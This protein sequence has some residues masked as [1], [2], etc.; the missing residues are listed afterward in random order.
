MVRE[1]LPNGAVVLILPDP[2]VP[3]V[4]MRAVWPGGVRLEDDADN[5]V[6]T[7]IARWIT[8][9]CGD[10]DAAA[11]GDAID[12]MGG[13]IAGS[14]G[15]NSFGLRAEWLA[16]TWDQGLDLFAD[17]VL[18]PRFDE[19]E[20]GAER[21]DLLE[22]LAA[23]D[24]S[25]SRAAFRLLAQTLFRR[26]PYRLDVAGS[27][28]AVARLTP[29]A[30]AAF[31][32]HHFPVSGMTLAIVGD[33][34]PEQVLARVRARFGGAPRVRAAPARVRAES[35]TG[36]SAA[37]REAYRY[38]DREQAQLVIGFPGT[39]V[40]SKDRFALEVLTT[41][42]GGQSGRLFAE[43]RE[44]RALAYRVS[45]HSV[46]GLDPGYV[47]IYLACSPDKLDEAEAAV[48]REVD[49]VVADGVTDAEVQR[50]VTYLVG[51]HEVAL[52][53]RSAVATALA[54]HEAYGLGWQEWSR[55]PER[56]ARVSAADV[57]RIA[58][59]YLRW[60]VAVTAAVRPPALTPAAARRAGQPAKKPVRARGKARAP[61]RAAPRRARGGS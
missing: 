32:R 8:R 1:V 26:H 21:R 4:A 57:N 9:G 51:A 35:F 34:D 31:Y 54:F 5:G 37:D 49:R 13:G 61:G 27:A 22:Q 58:R 38:L 60:D 47:A 17:C 15:R 39:T 36:R 14:A 41:I 33:V 43:L 55:Y 45:A 42:L 30:V 3:V 16:R 10:R 11:L 29:R 59:R 19:A 2:S 53:R 23:Q 40:T 28:A 24:D 50:A 18:R 7:L 12:R 46:E 20:L 6:T 25:P 52:Q 48:R 44:R 56:M